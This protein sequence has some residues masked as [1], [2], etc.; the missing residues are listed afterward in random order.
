MSTIERIGCLVILTLGLTFTQVEV[1]QADRPKGKM[2]FSSD[3]S[4][5]QNFN[6]RIIYLNRCK[7]GCKVWGGYPN[8]SSTDVSSIV[9][10]TK[11]ISEFNGNDAAWNEIVQNY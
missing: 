2:V 7:G 4:E 11:N 9:R 10:G 8:N 6:S 1:A 3:V 5:P